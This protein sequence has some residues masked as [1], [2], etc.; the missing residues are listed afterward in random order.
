MIRDPNSEYKWLSKIREIL[1]SV[2]RAD[3]WQNQENINHMHIHK[4]IKQILIDQYKQSWHAQLSQSNKGFI[5]QSFKEFHNFEEYFK[6]LDEKD[7]ITLFRFRTANH[8][9]PIEVG[10]YDGTATNERI[11][12]LCNADQIGSERHY[13]LYC[14]FFERDRE[15]FLQRSKITRRHGISIKSLLG[16]KDILIL[17]NLVKF[18]NI[19]MKKNQ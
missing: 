3:L 5:Y 19:I 2:G 1:N 12:T 10:R 9:L 11:C 15:N 8:K 13:L 14:N 7:Y 18:I 6:L 4:H 16:S 17:R